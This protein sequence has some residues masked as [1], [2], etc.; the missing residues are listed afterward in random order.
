MSE[1]DIVADIGSAEGNF[2]LSIIDK[3]KKI[4][5]FESDPEIIQALR[6]TFEPWKEKV[7]IVNKYVSDETDDNF[8]TL[9]SFF[10]DKEAPT[11][12]KIDVEGAEYAVLQGAKNILST[13]K[14]MKIA[15]AAYHRY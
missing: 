1:N 15:I 6:V 5:L 7:I 11:F 9:D 12:L 2:S 3:V 14:Q 4:Y 8:I 10:A 13:T